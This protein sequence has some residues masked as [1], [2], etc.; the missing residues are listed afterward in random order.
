MGY[1]K[2]RTHDDTSIKVE[3]TANDT[4]ILFAARRKILARGAQFDIHDESLREPES[5]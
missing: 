4:E 2:A 1:C 3:H 5:S